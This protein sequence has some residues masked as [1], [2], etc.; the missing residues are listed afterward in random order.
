[1]YTVISVESFINLVAC[2]VFAC[3]FQA[4]VTGVACVVLAV[5]SSVVDKQYRN[6]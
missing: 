2:G 6:V 3:V 5:N 4:A 1:M